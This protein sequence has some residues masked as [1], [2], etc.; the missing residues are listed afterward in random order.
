MPWRV[1][2]VLP[3]HLENKELLAHEKVHLDQ[4]DRMGPWIFTVVYLW[5]MLR[6]GYK[7]HPLEVEARQKSGFI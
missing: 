7:N 2:Y 6:Y 3:E 5:Y 1:I 4:I